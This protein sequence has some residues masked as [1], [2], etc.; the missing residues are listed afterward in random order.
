MYWFRWWDVSLFFDN[1]VKTVAQSTIQVFQ[2]VTSLFLT[3]YLASPNEKKLQ[4]YALSKSNRDYKHVILCVS[5]KDLRGHSTIMQYNLAFPQ[6]RYYNKI[7]KVWG[8]IKCLFR[9]Y[10]HLTLSISG[11]L[12]NRNWDLVLGVED[13]NPKA[14]PSEVFWE[15]DI[16]GKN[17]KNKHN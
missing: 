12:T 9:G 15:I 3:A 10:E 6:I 14:Q 8:I 1:I 4:K 11:Y 13:K 7:K 2:I 5:S 16:F 17:K